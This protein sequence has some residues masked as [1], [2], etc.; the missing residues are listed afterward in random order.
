MT[1]PGPKI[2]S[3]RCSHLRTCYG[4]RR[5][6]LKTAP[7]CCSFLTFCDMRISSGFRELDTG[8]ADPVSG[9]CSS[10]PCRLLTSWLWRKCR[11]HESWSERSYARLLFHL[12]VLCRSGRAV[13]SPWSHSSVNATV[14]AW[15]CRCPGTWT[16]WFL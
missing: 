10:L 12:R 15:P 8:G 16:R 9:V 5:S 11:P 14:A 3:S 1:L 4:K 7:C 2:R 6:H 13:S